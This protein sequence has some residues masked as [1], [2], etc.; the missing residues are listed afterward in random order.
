MKFATKHDVNAPAEFAA[1]VLAD[2]DGWE[3]M[4]ARRG[5]EIRRTDAPGSTAAAPAPGTVWD[6]R[7]SFRGKTREIAIRL[8]A[9]EP[10]GQM[11]FVAEAR[12]AMAEIKV[13][14]IGMA[15]TRTRL[16][17]TVDLRPRTLGARLFIQSL[18][19]ARSRVD[20]RFS[21]RVAEL[22]EHIESRFRAV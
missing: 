5:V 10:G 6:T 8:V 3:R 1:S 18:R 16:A 22:A 7:Y 2:F 17:V 11:A 21:R 15:A 14:L 13:D 20:T 12:P 4:A 19:L 9:L